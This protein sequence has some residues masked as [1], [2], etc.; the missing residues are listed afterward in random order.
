MPSDGEGC[1]YTGTVGVAVCVLEAMLPHPSISVT[2]PFAA[3]PAR[4]A[5]EVSGYK[6]AERG[7]FCS[8]T[9]MELLVRLFGRPISHGV[10]FW[11]LQVG[12]WSAFG[13]MM[14]GYALAREPVGPAI[15]D[16]MEL[17]VTGLT[18][19]SLYRYAYRRWRRR[20]V[21]LLSLALRIVLL[22]LIGV[23]IWYEPQVALSLAARQYFPS[24]VTWVPS[25][26]MI[27][28]DTWLV[29]GFVLL[30]WSFLYFGVNDW[31]SLQVE[32]RRA[33]AAEALVQ[34]ARLHALQSQLQPHFLFNTLNSI[35]SLVLDG[36]SDAAVTMISRVADLLRLCLQTSETPQITLRKELA[37]LGYYLDIES[38][39]F[40]DRL[41]CRFDAP[42]DALDLMVPTLLLQPLVENAVRHGILPSAKGGSIVI[43]ARAQGQ[44][45]TLRIEDD[46]PG[47]GSTAAMSSGIGLANTAARLQEL[48]GSGARMIVGQSS[49]GGVGIAIHIPLKL[50]GVPDFADA[51]TRKCEWVSEPY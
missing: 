43:S 28:R 48:Y 38:M 32:R 9:S 39:R 26:A 1:C 17:V 22:T 2:A 33:A 21:P 24:L 35:A 6:E 10:L 42:A 37:F 7:A 25:Y 27:P 16:V 36:R 20:R 46:G 3:M 40:G 44:M 14:F 50:I 49:M 12:G 45:L 41:Q 31:M 51:T 13:L 11:L 15:L 18:L 5:V 8:S 29:W 30:C 23:P 34:E 19:T 4:G 47:M